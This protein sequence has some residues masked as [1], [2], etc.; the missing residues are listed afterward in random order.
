MNAEETGY[1]PT[2]SHQPAPDASEPELVAKAPPAR[3]EPYAALGQAVAAAAA[4]MAPTFIAA[5]DDAVPDR[6][7]KLRHVREQ[8]PSNTLGPLE[9]LRGRAPSKLLPIADGWVWGGPNLLVLGPTRVGKTS[10]VALL[11]RLLLERS[12]RSTECFSPA[13][14]KLWGGCAS[15]LQLAD[16][17][18]WQS[19][20]D[21]TSA[22]REYPLGQGTPE[23]IQ[24]CSHARLL[25][26]DD[27]GATDD[28]GALERILNVRYER[29]WPT[30]TTSGLTSRELVA[31][32]GESLVRRMSERAGQPG[33]SVNL[34]T[35]LKVVPNAG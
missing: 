7:R 21:L 3:P 11:V 26:L 31:A 34:F 12:A 33:L 10:G 4:A 13:A 9:E 32:F 30:I 20:R 35:P 29:R 1:V 8:L 17:I 16:L 19:C 23:T 18:R 28:K 15:Q 2:F 5:D 14:R 25:V 22:V 27:V 6:L 24:R